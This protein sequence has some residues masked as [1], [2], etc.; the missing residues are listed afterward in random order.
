MQSQGDD[1]LIFA[2]EDAL[3]ITKTPYHGATS[4]KMSS[5][6]TT[7]EVKQP[8][9]LKLSTPQEEEDDDGGLKYLSIV[10]FTRVKTELVAKGPQGEPHK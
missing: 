3:S 1:I 6:G 5:F 2:P 4:V 8:P 7:I 10:H 9:G